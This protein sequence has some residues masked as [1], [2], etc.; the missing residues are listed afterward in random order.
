MHKYLKNVVTLK[1]DTEK[2]TGCGMCL[3]VCP[4]NV[5]E[6]NDKKAAIVNRDACMECGA[7]KKN[8]PFGA[9][10]V[11]AGVGC[12]AA[13]ILGAIKGTEP[14]C[15]SCDDPKDKSKKSSCC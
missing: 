6:I 7:C 1:L 3:S 5:F 2:C 13:I 14:T 8:C 10:D 11:R 9:I 12:A 15:G 4:H